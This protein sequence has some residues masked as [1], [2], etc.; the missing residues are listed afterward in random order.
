MFLKIK[1]G[2]AVIALVAAA[3]AGLSAQK[4]DD[5]AEKMTGTPVMWEQAAVAD[6]DLMLGPGGEEMK[7]D[8]SKVVFVE[9]EKGGYSK[10]YRSKTRPATSG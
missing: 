5:K 4:K 3:A 6:K 9:E 7:P 1:N 8:L 2:A 10:K